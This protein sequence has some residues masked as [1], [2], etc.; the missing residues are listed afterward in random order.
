VPGA[1]AVAETFSGRARAA[2]PAF[3]FTIVNERI[4]EISLIADPERL[5]H[6]D[7]TVFD[8]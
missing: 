8:D 2:R 1:A 5:R 4:G 3:G 6:L 7:P